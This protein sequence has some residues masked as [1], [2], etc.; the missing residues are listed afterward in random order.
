MKNA[1]ISTL[2]ILHV[3]PPQAW[4]HTPY[5]WSPRIA[6]S[7]DFNGHVRQRSNWKGELW[8]LL[9]IRCASGP[10][11]GRLFFC[12][13]LG[14]KD[15]E[16]EDR[17]PVSLFAALFAL[18]YPWDGS[19]LHR[20]LGTNYVLVPGKEALKNDRPDAGRLPPARVRGAAFSF[21]KKNFSK[22][23]GWA[24]AMPSRPAGTCSAQIAGPNRP[25][26]C[27]RVSFNVEG[28]LSARMK[29]LFCFVVYYCC[30]VDR[31][32]SCS[33]SG[34]GMWPRRKK[35]LF[36]LGLEIGRFCCSLCTS[37]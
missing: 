6:S 31:H 10:V 1:S 27:S 5:V 4:L 35:N 15:W 7:D 26:I 33:L 32:P 11:C 3:P 19:T 17:S 37:T 34:A 29:R 24:G 21:L 22:S 18:L 8:S 16:G 23:G 30:C 9:F 12:Q 20:I 28:I 25:L 2:M 13:T 36:C 14:K